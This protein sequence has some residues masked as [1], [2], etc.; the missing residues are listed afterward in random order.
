M[1]R[2]V[3]VGAV[4]A[5][6]V[7]A[8]AAHAAVSVSVSNGT[9][10]PDGSATVPVSIYCTP[11]SIVIEAHLSLSQDDGAI[12]GMAGIRNVR[13][14]GKPTTYFVTVTPNQGRFHTGTVYASPYVLVQRRGT[15]DTESAGNAA[16]I[17]LQ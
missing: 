10:N 14:T 5:L 13:C 8:P 12:W 6:L 4:V 7:V 3:L 15:G 11:G 16:S 1:R 2:A 17:S 9:A